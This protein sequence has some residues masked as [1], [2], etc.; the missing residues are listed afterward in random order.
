MAPFLKYIKEEEEESFIFNKHFCSKLLP[1][2]FFFFVVKWR[3][4]HYCTIWHWIWNQ[5]TETATH[6]Q[7]NPVA[8]W[9]QNPHIQD[10]FFFV[11]VFRFLGRGGMTVI[12]TAFC[13]P[14]VFRDWPSWRSLPT[15]NTNATATKFLTEE[16]ASKI[17][18]FHT[19]THTH[20][21]SYENSRF[22]SNLN[23]SNLQ[24][25][26]NKWKKK[27]KN[28]NMLKFLMA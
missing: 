14:W 19:H 27:F 8:Q 1:S 24:I 17:E 12:W 28:S 11:F 4:A 18:S 22:I 15:Q 9:R 23:E 2:L 5:D 13:L 26:F 25:Q 3:H 16:I 6:K 7:T 21:P 10:V 20:T